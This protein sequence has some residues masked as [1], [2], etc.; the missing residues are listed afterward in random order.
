ME[1]GVSATSTKENLSD[2]AKEDSKTADIKVSTN[3]RVSVCVCCVCVCVV[4]VCVCVCVWSERDCFVK[5]R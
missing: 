4:C 2:D 5:A 3:T 1:T